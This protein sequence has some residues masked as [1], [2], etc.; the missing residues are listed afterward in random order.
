[1]PTPAR[2]IAILAGGGSLPREIADCASRRGNAVSIVAL[3]GEADADF[4][5]Y[6][7]TAVNWGQI[8]AMVRALKATGAEDLVFAGRVR[9]PDLLR[10]RPDM[11]FFRAIAH[12]ASI[13]VSGGDDS[14]LRA[15]IR[16]F[17]SKGLHV[18]GVG[19]AAPELVIAEGPVGTTAVPSGSETDMQMGLD[20]VRALGPYDI[21]QGVVVA[22]GRVEAVE[23][24]DGTD[25][26]LRRVI[27]ERSA[28]TGQKGGVLVKRTKPG[29]D[30]RVD[31]PAIGPDTVRRAAEAELA[32]I[33]VEA[34][35][36]VAL[37]RAKLER[38]SAETGV[39]VV[40]ITDTAEKKPDPAGEPQACTWTPLNGRRL[41]A[42]ASADA[43]RG[44]EILQVM[45]RFGGSHGVVVS[46]QHVLAVESGEG[47]GPMLERAAGL[48]QWGGLGWRKAGMALITQPI[49]AGVIDKVAAARLAGVI[50]TARRTAHLDEALQRAESHGLYI[51]VANDLPG[52][53]Q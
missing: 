47:T 44:L 23:A 52:V 4:G 21:G 39:F 10:L 18:I 41:S 2:R 36:V 46:R 37:E 25:A 17:E 19:E 49:D 33:A 43:Q 1:M 34:D 42:R 11:G 51:G 53:S 24:A 6:S 26:M 22:G 27:R 5:D 48:V 3:E 12:V 13:I 16:F 45:S 50:S 14:V 7:V 31:L 38:A 35:R 15:V 28:D 9:R 30:L 20:L 29:Q 8:G 40:G 32:G